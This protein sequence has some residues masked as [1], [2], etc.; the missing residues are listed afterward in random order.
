MS[1]HGDIQVNGHLL[2]EW[3]AQRVSNVDDAVLDPDTVSEYR[4]R[5]LTRDIDKEFYVNHRYGDG[6]VVLAT[7][8]LAVG[9][10][11]ARGD[12]SL[13]STERLRELL[14]LARELGSHDD[15]ADY[16]AEIVARS[17]DCP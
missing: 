13:F 14:Q 9:C 6:P 4:C 8:V 11:P 12:L 10:A 3:S 5:V 17:E 16:E 1:L 7:K 2:G 15:A